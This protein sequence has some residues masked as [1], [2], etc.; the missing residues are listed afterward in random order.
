MWVLSLLLI[1][2]SSSASASSRDVAVALA[3]GLA[4]TFSEN[5]G[6][7]ENPPGDLVMGIPAKRLERIKRFGFLTPWQVGA[8]QPDGEATKF[9]Q[10]LPALR[11]E[12][13]RNLAREIKRG[14]L[15]AHTE[16][17]RARL[18]DGQ[19]GFRSLN[20]TSE[21][22]QAFGIMDAYRAH[23]SPAGME[24]IRAL[25]GR[26]GDGAGCGDLFCRL[27]SGCR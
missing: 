14:S 7:P 27:G 9:L 25:V 8:N 3:E 12:I 5:S 11:G 24:A 22:L 13:L 10:R 26:A 6:T 20:V 23:P 18:H 4:S 17:F 16:E 2:A 15:P 1:I 19:E 21:E